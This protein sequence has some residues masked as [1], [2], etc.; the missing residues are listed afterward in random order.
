[1]RTTVNLDEHVLENAR[2]RARERGITLGEL[3]EDALRRELASL[4]GRRHERPRV[5]VFRGGTGM[6]PGIDPSS[7]RSMR[8]ALDD[9]LPLEKLR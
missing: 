8:E 9:G 1:M 3:V 5:P 4:A 2:R 6:R 7:N